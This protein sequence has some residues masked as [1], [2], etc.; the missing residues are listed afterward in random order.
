MTFWFGVTCN[1]NIRGKV[2]PRV[3]RYQVCMNLHN[4]LSAR[5]PRGQLGKRPNKCRIKVSL[6]GVNRKKKGG[7]EDSVSQ[8]P[9][10]THTILEIFTCWMQL[11]KGDLKTSFGFAGLPW[12][13][14]LILRKIISPLLSV[15]LITAYHYW[16]CTTCGALLD[17]NDND[18]MINQV[19]FLV[20]LSR[21]RN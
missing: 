2:N 18:L 15:P 7:M 4:R 5:H 9:Q 13:L 8:S 19:L 20:Q 17:F 21:W 16:V 10:I 11:W 3:D 6:K 1:F 14:T 12:A